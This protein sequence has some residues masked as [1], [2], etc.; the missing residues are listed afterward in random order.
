MR[1]AP[2]WDLGP[3][4]LDAGE[5]GLVEGTDDRQGSRAETP[6][7]ESDRE[8]SRALAEQRGEQGTQRASKGR[9]GPEGE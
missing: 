7:A 5:E 6:C 8:D 1:G 9:G 2:R 3:Q 4:S